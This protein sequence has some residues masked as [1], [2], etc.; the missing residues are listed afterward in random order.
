MA[1]DDRA[2]EGRGLAGE[3]VIR[4]HH[5]R[6]RNGGKEL[7]DKIATELRKRYTLKD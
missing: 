2:A 4:S 5:R 7:A 1:L 3:R 6:H